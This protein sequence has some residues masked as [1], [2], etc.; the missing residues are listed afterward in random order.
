[1]VV[2]TGIRPNL[3]L[4]REA[5]LAVGRGITVND[6]MQTTDPDVY[7]A[8]ECAEHRGRVY[9]LVAPGLEQAG[10]AVHH[11]L[12][13]RASY[14]GSIAA[15]KLKVVDVP[16]FSM[17]PVSREDSQ[18]RF[19]SLRYGRPGEGVYRRIVK[20]RGRLVGVVAV[21]P[22]SELNRAQEAVSSRRVVW[23][24]NE[25]RFLR[26]GLL[27][28]EGVAA[29]VR[30]WAASSVVCNCTGVT[31]GALCGAMTAGCASVEDLQRRTGAS[32]VCGSCRH[33]LAD[34]LG[35][36][37]AA[38][39][40]IG[41]K[42]LAGISAAALALVLLSLFA[43]PIPYR[44]SVQANF[45]ID[46][47]W[48]DGLYKQ[49]SGFSLVG[50]SLLGLLMSLRKRWRRFAAGKFDHWRLFHTGL[51]LAVLIVL[52]AHTGLRL[53]HNLNM[54]LMTAFLAVNLLGAMSG[55]VT[56]MEHRLGGAAGARL[57]RAFTLLHILMCW[58]LPA[59]LGFH[60]LAVYYF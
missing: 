49:V 24:W 8:G 28:G 38:H 2:C 48:T 55:G 11:I 18:D 17:G 10:V 12:G 26:T 14:R 13:G 36:A 33:L 37:P 59:L 60:I 23:P 53:G 22:W 30:D 29:S 16:V 7:A 43:G 45:P 15:T 32:T 40:L 20:D 46:L 50:L 52:A 5:G 51:G 9:G 1:M 25:R 57:R 19:R 3:E 56:A 31:Q 35:A 42:T 34:L 27:W 6:N 41:W 44:E 54:M 21:G 4:A 39:L 58:P 47:L